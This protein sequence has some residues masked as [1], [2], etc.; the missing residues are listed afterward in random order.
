MSLSWTISPLWLL[1]SAA[2]AALAAAWL[3]GW[4]TQS[5]TELTKSVRLLLAGLRFLAFFLLFLLLLNPVLRHAELLTLRPVI[6]LVA[7]NSLSIQYSNAGKDTAE[8]RIA[9]NRLRAKL[10]ERFEISN[11][12]AGSKFR[13]ADIPDFS[14]ASTNL[15]QAIS[16]LSGRKAPDRLAAVVLLSDG[17]YNDGSN[18]VF[19]ASQADHPWFTLALGDS[20][21]KRDAV[22]EQIQAN[23]ICYKGDRIQLIASL[24]AEDLQGEQM[25]I[26][27]E[28]IS[29]SGSELLSSKVIPITARQFKISVSE[30]AE[31]KEAGLLHLRLTI[32]PLKG[33]WS[34]R[35]NSKDIFIEVLDN[36]QKILIAGHSPHP[37]MAA[38]KSALEINKNYAVELALSQE[39]EQKNPAD[40]SMIVMHQL[41]SAGEYPA[42]FMGR[43]ASNPRPCWYI[44]GSQS[45]AAS[46]RGTGTCSSYRL[47]WDQINYA[48]A[49]LNRDF[50]LFRLPEGAASLMATCPPLACGFGRYEEAAGPQVLLWQKVN[51]LSTSYP[52]LSFCSSG[53]SRQAMLMG[54]G[55]WKWRMQDVRTNGNQ[56][57]FNGIIQAI[58][59]YLAAKDDPRPFRLR[60]LAP[61]ITEGTELTFTAELYN[62]SREAVTGPEVEMVLTDSAGKERKFKFSKGED[63]YALNAGALP[64]GPYRFLAKTSLAAQNYAVSGE[65]QIKPS[66]LEFGR[67]RA[68]FGLLQELSGRTAALSFPAKEADRLADSI[69]ARISQ[70]P[71]VEEQVTVS[72]LIDEPWLMLA[73]ALLL[74]A[75]WFI[76]KWLGIL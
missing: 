50:A 52:L 48:Q 10:S 7:D 44:L 15:S 30:F 14:D 64:A 36:R 57:T 55:L 4:W 42:V 21:R 74:A 61:L 27:W 67:S 58:V 34:L 8:M 38:L 60:P 69:L 2:L 31:A 72:G 11:W 49:E 22:L 71:L 20:S 40:Y 62:A 45:P 39:L 35:N 9:L 23:A 68:D 56:N 6:A 5:G 51:Q 29:R 17:L 66:Q 63:S 32:L 28:R 73:V 53:N 41:P 46:G 12:L 70:K 37:D 76:R 16:G 13:K 19:E 59:Q 75:E 33:E 47:N 24:L 26:R 3:Y 65:V 1:P 43:L 25:N 54:E 18:P